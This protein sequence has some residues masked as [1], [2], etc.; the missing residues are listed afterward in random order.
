MAACRMMTFAAF[1]AVLLVI[2]AGSACRARQA[3]VGTDVA[4]SDVTDFYYTY[5]TSTDPPHYQRYRFFIDGGQRMFYHETR[6]GGGWPQTEKDITARG[7]RALSEAEWAE[8]FG[9]V[10]GGIVED[11]REHLDS[12]GAGPWLFLYWKGDR[13]KCQEFSFSSPAARFAFEDLCARL[14]SAR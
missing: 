13:G 8:F 12:G 1:A 7:S 2:L 10:K 11:R 4:L 9:C 6:E 3:T 14:K 5:S